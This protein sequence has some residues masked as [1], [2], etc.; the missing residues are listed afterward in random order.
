MN[1]LIGRIRVRL[2][3][4]LTLIISPLKT[5]GLRTAGTTEGGAGDAAENEVEQ[6]RR[7]LERIRLV[8]SIFETTDADRIDGYHVQPLGWVA[9]ER[10]ER[11]S[12][13][14]ALRDEAARTHPEANVLIKLS[15]TSVSERYVAGVG[16]KGNAYY[17]SRRKTTWEALA[18]HATPLAEVD[19]PARRWR[20][21]LA[22]V[23]GS[24]VMH[25]DEQ[26][27]K[28][29][30]LQ[31][32]IDLL[33]ANRQTPHVVFDR[34]AGFKLTGK[35]ATIQKIKS[36]MARDVNM[37]YCPPSEPADI[38][39]ISLAIDLGAPIVSNDQFKDSIRARHVPKIKGFSVNGTTE[40]L[41]PRP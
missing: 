3:R 32:V 4:L 40:L 39:I 29:E 25:W 18:A 38:S 22:I 41:D 20:S 31:A 35:P 14:Y 21:D 26:T 5:G 19:R 10:V 27:P 17:Q 30:T 34:N 11:S 13:E 15:S 8:S 23:D 28:I 6:A 24:N 37:E 16:A 2:N 36:L 33:L 9:S 1:D 12:A 7:Q